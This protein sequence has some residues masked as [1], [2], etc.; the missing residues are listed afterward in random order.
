MSCY[1]AMILC[2]NWNKVRNETISWEPEGVGNILKRMCLIVAW[3]V[4][5][6]AKMWAKWQNYATGGKN[7]TCSIILTL[8]EFFLINNK[9]E[10]VEWVSWWFR[11]AHRELQTVEQNA[12]PNH[13]F[14]FSKWL[15]NRKLN[16]QKICTLGLPA[17][18]PQHV[19]P[20]HLTLNSQANMPFPKECFIKALFTFNT[21]VKNKSKSFGATMKCFKLYHYYYYY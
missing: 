19:D 4:R 6:T 14:Q 15:F 7:Q 1:P 21:Q 12:F 10:Q 2:K 3:V 17:S 11:K 5:V 20:H 9:I 8:F 18:I 16:G 13:E